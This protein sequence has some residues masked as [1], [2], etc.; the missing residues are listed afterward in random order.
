M[1]T[2]HHAVHE[3]GFGNPPF[4]YFG[5][6]ENIYASCILPPPMFAGLTFFLFQQCL[7]EKYCQCLFRV[8]FPRKQK[9]T[10]QTEISIHHMHDTFQGYVENDQLRLKIIGKRSEW[11]CFNFVSLISDDFLKEQIQILLC[12]FFL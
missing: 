5:Y 6:L 1:E 8:K 4:Q 11:H 3:I 10:C 2:G 7:K 12:G 9:E